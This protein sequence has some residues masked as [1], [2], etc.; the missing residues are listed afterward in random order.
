[1]PELLLIPLLASMVTAAAC[2][3]IVV[4]GLGLR[5]LHLF[6][7]CIVQPPSKDSGRSADLAA[8]VHWIRLFGVLAA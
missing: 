6:V 5:R 3:L 4:K 1:M 7:A 2:S 8:F